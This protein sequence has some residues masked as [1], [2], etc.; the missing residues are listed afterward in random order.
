MKL[1]EEIV[2]FLYVD[3]YKME[4]MLKEEA[5]GVE[6]RAWCRGVT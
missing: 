6:G 4:M 1:S 2:E 5:A 3:P